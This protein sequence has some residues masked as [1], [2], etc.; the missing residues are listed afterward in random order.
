LVLFAG[1]A[2]YGIAISKNSNAQKIICVELGRECCKYARENLKLNKVNNVEIIQGNVKKI[3]EKLAKKGERFDK[4]I[5]PR[6][7][8]KETFLNSAF[9]VAKKGTKIY[10]YDF[11]REDE[12]KERKTEKT[13]LTEAKKCKRK[14][15]I[16]RIARVGDIAPYKYR[17]RVDFIVL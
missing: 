11:C 7:Q 15:E 12:I 4:I 10:Y 6:P 16:L 2:P 1:V 8:L 9:K 5:M 13:I 3:T 14:I 17:I